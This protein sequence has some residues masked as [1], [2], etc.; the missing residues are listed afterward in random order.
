[1][2]ESTVSLVVVGGGFLAIAL[3]I[4][5]GLQ[6]FKGNLTDRLDKIDEGLSTKLQKIGEDISAMRTKLDAVWDVIPKGSPNW[7]G[8]VTR[9]L[10]NLGKV[11]ISANPREEETQYLISVE[12]GPLSE[13]LIIALTKQTTFNEYEKSALEGRKAIIQQVDKHA[14]LLDIPATDPSVVTDYVTRFVELM[15]T[16]YPKKR[17]S[18]SAD[19]EDPVLPTRQD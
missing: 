6:N 1:M 17:A 7:T 8:T 18:V 2:S 16:E 12:R 15:D 11:E 3:T 5:F 13:D 4:W 9:M 14:V 10:P 19:Y